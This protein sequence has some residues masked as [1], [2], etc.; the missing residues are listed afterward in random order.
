LAVYAG[1]LHMVH[2]GD[3]S[4]HIW[5]SIFD[6]TSWKTSQGADG[7]EQLKGQLSKSSPALAAFAG[8]LHMVHLGDSSNHIWW[9]AFDGNMW[10][11]NTRIRCQLSKA[12][13]ELAVQGGVLHMMH[14]GDSSN[15]LWWSIYDGSAWTPN[16]ALHG[17]L[18]KATPALTPLPDGSG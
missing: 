2:L 9:S 7:N 11:S 16:L 18:S 15:H 1:G 3:S 14:L 6:G 12:P 13:P 8:K 10:W 5:W 4:N 17:Q